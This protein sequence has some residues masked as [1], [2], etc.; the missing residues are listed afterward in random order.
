MLSDKLYLGLLVAVCLVVY[1]GALHC[2]FVFDDVSAVKENKDLRPDTSYLDLFYN[3][4]WGT[5]MS[6]VCC[7]F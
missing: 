6:K 3:D 2:D 1:Q 5:P 7:L 4:F